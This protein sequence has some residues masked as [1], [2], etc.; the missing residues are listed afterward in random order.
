MIL[1][2]LTILSFGAAYALPIGNP[3]EASLYTNGLWW[4]NNCCEPCDP[5]FSWCDA[6]SIRAGFYGD[7]VFNRHMEIKSGGT[8]L[9]DI[10]KTEVYT[11]AGMLVLN[12][13]DWVEAF[14]TLGATD[15][16]ILT[17][18]GSFSTDTTMVQLD[19]ETDFSWSIGGRATI[20]ECDSFGVGVEG[21]YF[22]TTPNVDSLI[23]YAS[24]N[25]VYFNS[26][27]TAT[28]SEWQVGLGASY[29]WQTG[30]PGFAL[31]PYMGLK[32]AGST[33]DMN[34]LAFTFDSVAYTLRTLDAK[35]LWGYA[36]GVT[37][38]V[39][40]TVGATVEGRF[41]DEKAVSATMQIRF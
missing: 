3:S 16:R 41:A 23:R 4:G 2:T 20:W 35:K 7:Y 1:M 11:N 29:K 18:G 38:T 25:I 8:D 19:F 17:D 39:C 21:Q 34:D 33:L 40:D 32:W 26:N 28:Y 37:A 12:V 24:G 30:C 36:V 6:F 5:C 22:R 31:T 15:L 14:V 27:N 9:S 13:C 10:D